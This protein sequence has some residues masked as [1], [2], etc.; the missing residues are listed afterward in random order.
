M[1]GWLGWGSRLGEDEGLGLDWERTRVGYR[2]VD[3]WEGRAV[4][5]AVAANL[6][7]AYQRAAVPLKLRQFCRVITN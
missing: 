4:D 6:L 2:A 5:V 3:G 1:N 7:K